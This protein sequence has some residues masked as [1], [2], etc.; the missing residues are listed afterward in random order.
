YGDGHRI[1]QAS[2]EILTA[3]EVVAGLTL[4]NLQPRVWDSESPFYLA[5]LTAIMVSY[6]DF[7]LMPSRRQAAMRQG[8]RNYLGVPKHISIY[9]DNGAFYFASRADE[10]TAEE[11]RQFVREAKP[12]W[13]PI[14]FD[15]IPAPQM[16]WQTQAACF[17]KTMAINRNYQH[18][19]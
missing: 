14:R 1:Y 15:A 5:D 8:L 7:K 6:A 10:P 17:R 11:Y 4:K 16:A 19:G 9:L 12:D 13:R 3:M 2:A 18:D